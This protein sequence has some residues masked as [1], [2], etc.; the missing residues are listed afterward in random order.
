M[1][2]GASRRERI[3]IAED[4]VHILEMMTEFLESIDYTVFKAVNA[5]QALVV[6]DAGLVDLAIIDARLAGMGG[7]ELSRTI[8]K[9]KPRLPIIIQSADPGVEAEDALKAG[10]NA[11]VRKPFRLSNLE[12]TIERLLEKRDEPTT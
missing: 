4:N 5:R 7:I 6:L 1:P 2:M 8:R 3:L 9:T 10:A 12:Q 11:Y